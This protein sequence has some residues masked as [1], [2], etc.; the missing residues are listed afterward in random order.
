MPTK[1]KKKKGLRG[2]CDF[3]DKTFALL[4]N[5]PVKKRFSCS[6]SRIRTLDVN[7]CVKRWILTALESGFLE[8]HFPPNPWFSFLLETKF[9]TSNTL[10]KLTL[11]SR[12]VLEVDSVF[13][14]ALKSLSLL[15]VAFEYDYRWRL[16]WGCPAL[17]DLH[18]R[19]GDYPPEPLCFGRDVQSA[20]LKR[21]VVFTNQPEFQND[22]TFIFI[23]A[24]S[25]VYL[26]YS[27]YVSEDYHFHDLDLLV[28]AR[29][30]IWLW[31]STN[32]YDDYDDDNDDDDYYDDDDHDDYY[33]DK[34]KAIFGDVTGLVAGIS[35]VTTLHLSPDSL[36]VSFCL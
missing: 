34:P 6:M 8:I 18:I 29:L 36:E 27:S 28:E 2:F 1:K 20:S 9:L 22:H 23:Q 7:S 17:Q 19:D 24:P 14:P 11:S 35:N 4:S 31:V 3:V 13:F 26:D 30:D 16:L 32:D 10:V 15:S 25:L 21:L 5:A 33:N 12:C